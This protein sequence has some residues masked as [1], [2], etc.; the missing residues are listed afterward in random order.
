[1]E[2]YQCK[3]SKCG[4]GEENPFSHTIPLEVEHIDG[5]FQNN[6][7]D[8]LTLL[9]PNCHSLT[10][11]YKGA[12]KRNGRKDRE[13]YYTKQIA[14]SGSLVRIQQEAQL[15]LKIMI[16]LVLFVVIIGIELFFSPRIDLTYKGDI[17]LWYN[18]FKRQRDY[19]FLFK[20][21]E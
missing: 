9:C 2:K 17:L 20:V 15:K 19:I 4:W 5:N 8:N 18:N 16:L 12:N 10:P 13:K 11:T 21:E 7:E 14:I 3:C 6:R 1:M